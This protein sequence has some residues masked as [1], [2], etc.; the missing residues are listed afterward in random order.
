MRK[1]FV[2]IKNEG[3]V[4]EIKQFIENYF[5]D[6]V[7]LNYFDGNINII[8]DGSMFEENVLKKVK[9][10]YLFYRQFI[11]VDDFGFEVD[12][13]GG[14]LGVMFVRYVGERVIDEDRIKKFLDEL[15]DVLEDKRGVQFV[16]VFVF[17][18]Q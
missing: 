7:I 13:L 1:F 16:C 9:I 4:R 17:I 3:K 12:V 6:V 10:V 18:D 15:K 8:E 5:D 11:F 14:R 2:V